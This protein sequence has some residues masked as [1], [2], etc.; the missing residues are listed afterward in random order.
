M[1]SVLALLLAF[2]LC[3]AGAGVTVS[4]RPQAV[5]E[6]EYF[7]L[8]DIAEV[9]SGD[10]VA[11]RRLRELRIG[12]SPR[13][14]TTLAL[15]RG[16]VERWLRRVQPPLAAGLEVLGSDRVAVRRGSL[17]APEISV[18]RGEE[19]RVRA[20]SGAVV[21]ETVALAAANARAGEVI[22]VR[23]AASRQTYTVRVTGPGVAEALWR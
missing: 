22:R 14:A 8:G 9:R 13:V 19:V 2:G 11:E 12:V 20:A 18:R 6:G 15:E 5:V 23:N 21:I 4:L 3:P 7:L 17:Q 1:R 10:P 16:Q